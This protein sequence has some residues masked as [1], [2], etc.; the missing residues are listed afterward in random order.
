MFSF[1]LSGSVF[2]TLTSTYALKYMLSSNV[3][4]RKIP[5][6]SITMKESKHLVGPVVQR[7]K[8]EID[9]L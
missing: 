3:A 2:G 9:V 1:P 8:E 5:Y 6:N 4:V 7:W